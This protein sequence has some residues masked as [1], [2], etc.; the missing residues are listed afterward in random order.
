MLHGV[1]LVIRTAWVGL[2][3]MLVGLGA[4]CRGACRA[5]AEGADGLW[6]S[7]WIGWVGLLFALQIWHLFLPIDVRVLVVAATAG[8]VGLVVGG[9][10]PWV[11]L[12]RG[13]RKQWLVLAVL[14]GAGA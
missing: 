14:D 5:P 7:F 12:A 8:T 11:A 10:R 4:L 1:S 13:V 2:G 3:L 9:R 6:L